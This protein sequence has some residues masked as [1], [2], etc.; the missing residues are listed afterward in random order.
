MVRAESVSFLNLL[1]SGCGMKDALSRPIAPIVPSKWASRF[2]KGFSSVH[3][4][5]PQQGGVC[6]IFKVKGV[7]PFLGGVKNFDNGGSIFA[8][9]SGNG[10]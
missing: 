8:N 9:E 5:C 6:H 4:G 3:S 2:R 10:E 7:H 1:E